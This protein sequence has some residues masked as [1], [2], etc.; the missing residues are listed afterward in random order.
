MQRPEWLTPELASGLSITATAI[1]AALAMPFLGKWS[2]RRGPYGLLI[3]SL[4]GSS[5]VLI[6]QAL[7]P[8]VGLFL[9]MRAVLGVWLAGITAT[10]SVLT[11]LKAPAGREGAAFGAASSAQGL[12]WGIGPILGSV[13][14]ALGGIPLLYLMCGAVMLCLLLPALRGRPSP[15]A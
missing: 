8:T 12:G 3:V 5:V 7:V 10:L 14:V 15:A 13:L 11:K 6:V 2:D 4:V 1:T 9:L